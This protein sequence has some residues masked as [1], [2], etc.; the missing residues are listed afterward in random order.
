MN[1]SR[2]MITALVVCFL[3]PA[4]YFL[5]VAS[6]KGRNAAAPAA[7]SLQSPCA[8][9]QEHSL[10]L[11]TTVPPAQFVDFE[12]AI[13][14]FLQS[15]E[16]KR[17]GWCRDKGSTRFPLRDTGPFIQGVYYGTHPAVRVYY[18]P[19]AMEWLLAGRVGSLPDG[20]MIIKEQYRPPMARYFGLND[21]TLP[22]VADWTV[23]IKD[24]KGAK[25]GWFWGEFFDEMRFDDDQPPFQYPWAGFA[26][27]CLRC[28]GAAETEHT[29][30]S[31]DNVRAST[32]S[33]ARCRRLKASR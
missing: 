30:A 22:R 13:L 15:G 19:R 2:L 10:P 12:K 33:W 18:S 16:Y 32:P 3:A 24:S 1:P 31:L 14:T 17:L 28:H 25:D 8:D 5:A 11:P 6:A 29:F 9:A 7:H 4:G 21:D 20:A 23:M 26:L 27:Y